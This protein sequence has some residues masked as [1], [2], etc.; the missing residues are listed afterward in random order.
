MTRTVFVNGSYLPEDQAMV[1]VFDRGF[2]MADGVYEVTSVLDGKLI[3]FDGHTRRLHRSLDELDMQAPCSDDE[4]LELTT[5]AQAAG[6]PIGTYL[7]VTALGSAGPRA[8]RRPIIEREL[9]ARVLGHLGKIGSNLNQLASSTN[10]VGVLDRSKLDRGLAD[11]AEMRLAIL[12]A[13][14]R[15]A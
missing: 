14:G 3:D 1:S 10:A 6:L 7:R 13:L 12:E 5:R 8:R 4:L 11:V 2:L 9:L 15:A